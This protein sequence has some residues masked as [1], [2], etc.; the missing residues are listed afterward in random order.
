MKGIARFGTGEVTS[1]A[2]NTRSLP[3]GSR[4][5]NWVNG[6][7]TRVTSLADAAAHQRMMVQHGGEGD[8]RMGAGVAAGGHRSPGQT[9]RW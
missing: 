5:L 3:E 8:A 1:R 6:A 9:L 2:E 7:R 4:K